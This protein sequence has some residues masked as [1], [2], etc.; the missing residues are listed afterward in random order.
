MFLRSKPPR[1]AKFRLSRRA[2]I[3]AAAIVLPSL[4]TFLAIGDRAMCTVAERSKLI[5][6]EYQFVPERAKFTAWKKCASD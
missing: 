2:I 4:L 5:Q 6:N 1:L 3:I